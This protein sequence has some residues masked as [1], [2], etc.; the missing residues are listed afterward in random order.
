MFSMTIRVTDLIMWQR[1]LMVTRVAYLYMSFRLV[2]PFHL[3]YYILPKE[4]QFSALKV[5]FKAIVI[6]DLRE[7]QDHST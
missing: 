7:L 3:L 1:H 6:D 2:F 5:Y 4:F